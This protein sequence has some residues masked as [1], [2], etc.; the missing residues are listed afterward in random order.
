MVNLFRFIPLQYTGISLRSCTVRTC[1]GTVLAYN[2]V[3]G[4]DFVGVP[5]SGGTQYTQ[6]FSV[7]AELK[8]KTS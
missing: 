7:L 2:C 3:W 1:T 4:F 8:L 6:E 5:G